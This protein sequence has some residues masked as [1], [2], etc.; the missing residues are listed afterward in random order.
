MQKLEDLEEQGE[1]NPYNPGFNPNQILKE[2]NSNDDLDIT[3]MREA[4][5]YF[6]RKKSHLS[7]KTVKNDGS[8]LQSHR[9]AYEWTI[10][11]FIEKNELADVSP[12]LVKQKHFENIIFKKGIKMPTRKFYFRQLRVFWNKL[13][14][15]EIVEKN[16]LA[17]I[18]KDSPE[19]KSNILPKMIDERE[20]QILFKAYD[21][22]LVRKRARPDYDENLIQH[23]FKPMVSIYFYCGL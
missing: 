23:W 1:I 3:T 8:G 6:Y 10:E 7:D 9:G 18:K 5:D 13:I 12:K 16:Y 4:T 19:E 17:A 22:D 14:E 21:E 11:H 15:W 20:L 2:L